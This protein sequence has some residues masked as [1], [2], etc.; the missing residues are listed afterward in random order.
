MSITAGIAAFGGAMSDSPD[1]ANSA[2]A[3]PAKPK[4]TPPTK[5][6]KLASSSSGT[7]PTPVTEQGESPDTAII[8]SPL[9][10]GCVGIGLNRVVNVASAGASPVI[11]PNA[12]R[13]N[14]A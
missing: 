2:K 5:I 1:V 13:S 10:Y 8:F 11:P 4:L 6:P 7:V 14:Q 9:T 3:K 12:A